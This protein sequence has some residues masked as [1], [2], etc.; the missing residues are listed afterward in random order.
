MAKLRRL[1]GYILGTRY[2]EIILCIGEHMTVK[3]YIDAAYGV[4]QDSGKSQTGCVIETSASVLLTDIVKSY[5]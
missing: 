2:T 1:M 5:N 3:A 4:H